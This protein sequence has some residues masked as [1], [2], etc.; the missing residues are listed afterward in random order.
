MLVSSPKVSSILESIDASD[1]S[2]YYIKMFLFQNNTK[3]IGEE[4]VVQVVKN[5]ACKNVKS[6]AMLK[7]Y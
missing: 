1:S 3:N 7:A 5:D 6:R 2:T 4:N